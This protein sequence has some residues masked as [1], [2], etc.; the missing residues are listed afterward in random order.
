MNNQ[1]LSNIQTNQPSVQPIQ[2]KP[3]VQPIQPKPSVQ[4][5]QPKT[6]TYP[7][8]RFK[9]YNTEVKFKRC[10]DKCGHKCAYK[11][12]RHKGNITTIMDI[13]SKILL[14]FIIIYVINSIFN[15]FKLLN[16]DTINLDKIDL[17]KFIRKQLLK[18]KLYIKKEKKEED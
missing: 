8:S 1:T 14:F 12:L 6:N 11:K 13:I 2:P 5:V 16:R 7:T 17:I 3:S 10:Q 18:T 9:Q 4:P 15:G